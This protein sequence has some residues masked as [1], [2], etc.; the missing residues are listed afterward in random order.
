MDIRPDDLGDAELDGPGH[1]PSVLKGLMGKEVT[2]VPAMRSLRGGLMR[3]RMM[4]THV[5]TA[6]ILLLMLA[7]QL[8]FLSVPLALMGVF[9]G[10]HVLLVAGVH[11]GLAVAFLACS[12]GLWY[13][14]SWARWLSI[15]LATAGVIASLAGLILGLSYG[16][17]SAAGV[18]ILLALSLLFGFT[19]GALSSSSARAW[20][21]Y[22][23]DLECS[24]G[25][26]SRLG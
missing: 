8:A 21:V 2:K 14:K 5:R 6:V 24:S 3:R 18:F 12:G 20:F 16:Q 13:G 9:T 7:V 17:V 11:A 1:F 26:P 4:P 15:A 25:S 19:I 23:R 10:P 22:D